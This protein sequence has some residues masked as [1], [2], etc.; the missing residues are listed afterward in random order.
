MFGPKT[1]A[2]FSTPERR[3]ALAAGRFEP[4]A[5]RNRATMRYPL[6]RRE[7]LLRT[8][9]ALA[10]APAVGSAAATA[11]R[12]MPEPFRYCLNTSTLRG[13]K[14]TLVEEV[15]IAARAGYA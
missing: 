2:G 14:L 13:Q 6:R 7:L 4:S 9:T 11:P 12:R 1:S 3:A 15:E 8:G 10:I 5:T